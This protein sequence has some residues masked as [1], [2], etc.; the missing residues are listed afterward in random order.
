MPNVTGKAY[1]VIVVMEEEHWKGEPGE[2]I[3]DFLGRDMESLPQEEPLF[4]LI[5]IPPRAFNDIF[6]THRNLVFA[7]IST[8][9]RE[10]KV[11]LRRD[12]YAK[13]QVVIRI[14]AP[15]RSEF[16]KAFLKNADPIEKQLLEAERA[17]IIS[18]YRRFE[19]TTI[20]MKLREEHGMSLI[21]PRPF[22]WDVTGEDFIWI[23]SESRKTSQGILV[24]F[25]PYTDTLDFSKDQLITRRN[26]VL[27]KNVPGSLPGSYMTTEERVDVEHT[28]FEMKGRYFASLKGLWR[29]EGDFM[30]GPFTS[31]STYDEKRGRIV[32]V[33]GYVYAPDDEKRNLLRQVEAILYTLQFTDT[34]PD[35]ATKK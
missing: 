24:W 19:A 21:V 22:N 17:R 5:Q 30:A 18:N 29:A 9:K 26:E 28:S 2:T 11:T 4:D 1:E 27:K 35:E 34:L 7:D 6:K 14:E 31:L 12:V 25:Y 15:S 32:T 23:S 20:G 33:E 10:T 16:V 13:P 8:D 3:K